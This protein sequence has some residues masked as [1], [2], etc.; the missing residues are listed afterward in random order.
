ML[1]KVLD[2]ENY[3]VN[4]NGE[5]FSTRGKLLCQWTDNVGYKQVVLY[6]DGKRHYKRVHRLIYEAFNGKIPDKLIINH[7]DEDKNNNNLS[8]LEIITNRENIKYF[9]HYNELKSYDISVYNKNDGSFHN[10]YNSLRSLS[11]DLKL[12]RKTVANIINGTKKTNNYN[13]IFVVNDKA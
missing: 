9:H 10:R 6:K 1:K 4:E 12:N 7:I 11:I 8:N 2:F 5:V 13:Y 3:S